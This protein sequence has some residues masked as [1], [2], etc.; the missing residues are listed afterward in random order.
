MCDVMASAPMAGFL[1]TTTVSRLAREVYKAHVQPAGPPPTM[2]TSHS[3]SSG[4]PGSSHPSLTSGAGFRPG[5]ESGATSAAPPHAVASLPHDG[6]SSLAS[7]SRLA[8]SSR[9]VLGAG[10]STGGGTAVGACGP[11]S[12]GVAWRASH[13]TFASASRCSRHS[14]S[15]KRSTVSQ[16]VPSLAAV[17]T[18]AAT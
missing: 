1:S 14:S 12:P 11:L 15:R 5:Y 16:A 2:I 4:G 8:A 6:A 13:A 17:V 7:H 18:S 10:T 3:T 9:A